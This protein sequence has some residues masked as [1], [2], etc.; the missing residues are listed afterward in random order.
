ML[1]TIPTKEYI[2]TASDTD[3]FSKDVKRAAYTST[4]TLETTLRLKLGCRVMLVMNL[5][6]ADG[7]CNGAL[8]T[9]VDVIMS[10]PQDSPE[11]LLALWVVFDNHQIGH[12]SRISNAHKHIT[13]ATKILKQ[14]VH[15][16]GKSKNLERR[17]A[18]FPIVLAFATTIHKVQ[19]LS[20][21][22][23]VASL[24]GY[25]RPGM[26][27]VALSRARTLQGLFLTAFD[28]TKVK[29]DKRVSAEMDRLASTQPWVHLSSNPTIACYIC[30]L[31]VRSLPAHFL[32]INSHETLT[33]ATVLAL[34]ETWLQR[35]H[36]SLEFTLK[37]FR[38][39]RS[40]GSLHGGV[41][42]YARDTLN[43]Q[44]LSLRTSLQLLAVQITLKGSE[45][46][47]VVVYK[48][49]PD[50]PSARVDRLR[51]RRLRAPQRTERLDRA[52][53]ASRAHRDRVS[54]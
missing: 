10:P 39:H 24:D 38:L 32:D 5:N 30:L 45:I 54:K 35:H 25:S 22:K 48:P 42:L 34:T 29:C 28:E 6:V 43:S 8:G 49:P 1:E 51:E 44:V 2:S 47:L 31:N 40:D 26:T 23:V 36:L 16:A 17:R 20:L 21:D 15:L 11:K 53:L 19:G 18:Q 12:Q 13:L 37:H 4:A 9:L 7:L 52:P 27:Y 33:K 3:H 14:E 46:V 50:H 41:V